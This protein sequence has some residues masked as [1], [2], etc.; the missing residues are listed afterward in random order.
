MPAPSSNGIFA[1]LGHL[2]SPF[3]PVFE[4]FIL[5]WFS[6]PADGAILSS[7]ILVMYSGLRFTATPQLKGD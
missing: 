4:P 2:N 6:S 3:N 7:L 1:L 5:K